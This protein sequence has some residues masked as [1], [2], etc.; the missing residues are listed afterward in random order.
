MTSSPAAA[1]PVYD[2]VGLGYIA[3]RQVEP[4]WAAIINEQI[5]DGRV[6]V[7]VGAG[8]GNYE[9]VA[10]DVVAVEP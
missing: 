6:V 4:R 3:H 7:N 10:R 1:S 9:P 2:T 5:G 8:T